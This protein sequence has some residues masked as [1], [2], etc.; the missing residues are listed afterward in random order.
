MHLNN[1]AD[2]FGFTRKG[3]QDRIA[4]SIFLNKFA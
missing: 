3:I 1:P 4:P 2:P